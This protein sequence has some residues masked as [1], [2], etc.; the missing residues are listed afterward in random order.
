MALLAAALGSLQADG[1]VRGE[2]LITNHGAKGDGTF[3]NAA[4]INNLINQL[5]NTGGSIVIPHGDFRINSPVIVRKPYVTIRGLGRGSRLVIGAGVTD[6]I[7]VP[8]EAPRISGVVVRDLHIAGTDWGIYQTGLKVDRASDG[9]HVDQVSFTGVSRG[10]FLR[11]TDAAQITGCEVTQS[12]SSLYL[13]GGFMG[14]VTR[15]RFS[16]YSGG[17]SVELADLDRIVFSGNIIAPDGHTA[18][19]LRNAHSCNL[20]GNSIT[21]WYAGGI[22]V[23]GNMNCLTGNSISALQVNG[24]WVPDPRGRD[25]LWGLIRIRGNDNSVT[26]SSIVSWQPEND[27]RVNMVSGERNILRDLTIAGIGSNRKVNV[28][29]AAGWTRITCCGWP[30]ETNLNGNPTARVVYDP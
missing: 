20:S 10:M 26:S 25:G 29:P 11:A 6:G 2:F 22:E 12:Q 17:I 14:L 24:Q 7:L 16:G 3:D 13:Q 5:P 4:V 15:N 8:D 27:I 23:E 21:T 1:Q 30:Q 19:Q 18:L 9:F 28:D